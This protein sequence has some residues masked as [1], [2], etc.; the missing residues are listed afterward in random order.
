MNGQRWGV[1]DS[2]VQY[3]TVRNSAA[4]R[5]TVVCKYLYGHVC[6]ARRRQQTGRLPLRLPVC[7]LFPLVL[8]V[9]PGKIFPPGGLLGEAARL[10]ELS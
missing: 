9:Q 1:R 3:G 4:Q 5:D 2:M 7:P 6:A 10:D 8:A